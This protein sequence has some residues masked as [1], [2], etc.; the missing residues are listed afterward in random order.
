[1]PQTGPVE[2][3]R[4]VVKVVHAELRPL[5]FRKQGYNFIKIVNGNA[6]IIDFQRSQSNTM[7]R[8]SFTINVAVVCGCLLDPEGLPLEESKSYDGHIRSRVGML[9]FDGPEKWWGIS[10]STDKQVLA[11]EVAEV[12][13]RDVLP[14]LRL[15]L[16]ERSLVDLWNSEQ[17]PGLTETQRL[18]YLSKL[19]QSLET[20]QT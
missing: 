19:K 9:S 15:Y 13:C 7:E 1:M 16:D 10:L 8:V 6:A 18:R 5:G 20:R 14:W 11:N 17:S 2:T 4:H 3:L 12:V